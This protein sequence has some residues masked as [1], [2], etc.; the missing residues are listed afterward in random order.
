MG[1]RGLGMVGGTFLGGPMGG[2]VGGMVAGRISNAWNNAHNPHAGFAP[3]PLDMA[4][5]LSMGHFSPGQFGLVAPSFSTGLPNGYQT[6]QPQQF[7]PVDPNSLHVTP[8]T[9]VRVEGGGGGGQ[10]S[11]SQSSGSAAG[12]QFNRLWGGGALNGWGTTRGPNY[13]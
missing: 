2:K 6:I 12:M 3:M 7:Q 13:K 11:G 10:S 9:D 4:G 8:I 5:P 1:L